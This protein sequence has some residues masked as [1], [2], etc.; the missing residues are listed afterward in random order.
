ME[1]TFSSATTDYAVTVLHT[2]GSISF[3]PKTADVRASINVSMNGGSAAETP[4][5]T[6]GDP[7][8]LAYGANEVSFIVKPEDPTAPSRVYRVTVTRMNNHV[9]VADIFGLT[10]DEGSRFVGS[11]RG[12]DP[13]QDPLKYEL[14][15]GPSKGTIVIDPITGAFTYQHDR[16][17]TGADGFVYRV[18]D[19]T[20]YSENGA[21]AI[22]FRDVPE[23]DPIGEE[24]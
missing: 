9:P 22:F 17:T 20:S 18:Y 13:D 1:P 16:S 23:E 7:I 14:V 11:M 4:N 12:S 2:V 6:A 5:G 10:I 24:M 3:T 21:V 15:R 8:A 19:G